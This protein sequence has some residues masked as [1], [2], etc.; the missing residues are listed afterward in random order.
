[1]YILITPA[2]NTSRAMN[3]KVM[4]G[5]RHYLLVEKNNVLVRNALAQGNMVTL[6]GFTYEG[7]PLSSLEIDNL[8]RE[9]SKSRKQEASES[10]EEYRGNLYRYAVESLGSMGDSEDDEEKVETAAPKKR[11]SAKSAKTADASDTDKT[12]E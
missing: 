1:M 3:G 12:G 5:G 8:V 9:L 7:K 6:E 10:Y 4:S 2:P 11:Q